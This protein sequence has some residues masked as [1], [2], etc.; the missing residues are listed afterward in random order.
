[1]KTLTIILVSLMIVS[2]GPQFRTDY[3]FEPPQSQ[4]G[5]NCTLQCEPNR[6]QCLQIVELEYERCEINS[7][8]SIEYCEY[9]IRL[10]KN[11]SSKWYECSGDSCSRDTEHCEV[12][13]RSCFQSCGGKV[14]A[15]TLCVANC[16]QIKPVP[17]PQAE[18]K[19]TAPKKKK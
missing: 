10:T 17:A 1:M 6:D 4:S 7:Q 11:R 14:N 16:D 2:C 3:V 19:K 18:H 13:Y 9:N 5:I 8:R 15:V 12:N